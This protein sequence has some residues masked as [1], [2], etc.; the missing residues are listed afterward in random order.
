MKILRE[1]SREYKGNSYFRFRIN[2]PE[3]AVQRAQLKEGDDVEV[4]SEVGEILLS[5]KN[6]K[7]QEFD[8][9]R[10]KLYREALT[11]F[12]EARAE[13]IQIMKKYLNPK[14]DERILEIGAGTGFFS[15]HIA[16]MLG[17]NG[18]LIVSDPSKDQLEEI[19]K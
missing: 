7:K 15:P 18:R 17:N 3:G 12:P 6:K 19:K 10:S 2:I 16:D 13:D 4:T 9:L 1:K 8:N 5:Q 11:E 14:N